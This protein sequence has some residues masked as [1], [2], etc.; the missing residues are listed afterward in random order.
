MVDR[1]ADANALR[2]VARDIVTFD[3]R[4]LG[5]PSVCEASIALV[6]LLLYGAFYWAHMVTND[7]AEFCGRFRHGSQLLLGIGLAMLYLLV[8]NF[9]SFTKGGFLKN[10]LAI[11]PPLLWLACC[12]ESRLPSLRWT[13]RVVTIGLIC[14]RLVDVLS[15][16]GATNRSLIEF[17]AGKSYL[18]DNKT[19]LMTLLG[20]SRGVDPFRHAAS[21][22]CLGSGNIDLNNVFGLTRHSPVRFHSRLAKGTIHFG[23]YKQP[24][25]V[26]AIVVWGPEEMVDLQDASGFVP[27]FRA[28]RLKIMTRANIAPHAISDYMKKRE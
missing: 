9:F 24:E 8:P 4:L 12:E 21:Y 16:L 22:Y 10:R 11:F 19:I 20:E 6:V 15:W 13:L 2:S 25:L 26:D 27:R 28:G 7:G 18:G 17:T 5:P 3:A 23:R 1:L 14:I